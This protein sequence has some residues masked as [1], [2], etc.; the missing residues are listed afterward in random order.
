MTKMQLAQILAQEIRLI[1]ENEDLANAR[2]QLYAKRLGA[3]IS[4]RVSE[5]QLWKWTAKLISNGSIL[6]AIDIDGMPEIS[7]T[8]KDAAFLLELLADTSESTDKVFARILAALSYDIAGYQA[9]ALCLM[10]D[11]GDYSLDK[12]S[13]GEEFVETFEHP[14]NKIIP[15]IKLFLEKKIP[16]S[17]S[18]QN[19][20]KDLFLDKAISAIFK[21]NIHI[22]Q[23]SNS[24]YFINLAE[25]YADSFEQGDYLTNLSFSLLVTRARYFQ[26]RSLWSVISACGKDVAGVWGRYIR[27]KTNDLYDRNRI[28]PIEL[29]RSRFEF[30]ESQLSAVKAGILTTSNSYAIQMPTSAGKTMIGELIGLDSLTSSA[31]GKCL[32]IAPFRALANQVEADLRESLSP[33]GFSI[34]TISGSFE[35]DPFD[36]LIISETDVLVCTPEK[37]DILTRLRPEYFNNLSSVIIDEGHILG[38]V[39][40]GP[41]LELLIARLRQKYPQIRIAFISAVMP[42]ANGRQIANWLS[43]SDSGLIQAPKLENGKPWQPTQK[44]FGFFWWDGQVGEIVFPEVVVGRT[45]VNKPELAFARGL[46]DKKIVTYFTEKKRTKKTRIFPTDSNDKGETSALLGYEFAKRGP[47]LVF[48]PRPDWVIST[49]NKLLDLVNGLEAGGETVHSTFSLR[50]DL[51]SLIPALEW[52][53][54]HSTEYK[55]LRRGIGFHHGQLP[56]NLRRS[57]EDDYRDGNIQILFA[58][59]TVSQGINFPIKYLIVHSLVL[60]GGDDS[61]L[62]QRISKRDF[63][64]LVGRAGRAGRETEGQVIFVANRASDRATYTE[65]LNQDRVEP[66]ESIFLQVSKLLTTGRLTQEAFQK[67]VRDFSEPSLLGLLV[68][69]SISSSDRDLVESLIGHTLFKAQMFE[70]SNFA[71]ALTAIRDT[72]FEVPSRFKASVEDPVMRAAFTRTGLSLDSNLALQQFVQDNLEVISTNIS[73]LDILSIIHRNISFFLTSEIKEVTF[74][75]SD[76]FL[77]LPEQ[78]RLVVIESWIR[79]EPVGKILRSEIGNVDPHKFQKLLSQGLTYRYPWITSAILQIYAASC[80]VSLDTLPEEIRS[81]PTYLK[82]GVDNRNAALFLGV[83]VPSRSLAIKLSSHVGAGDVRSTIEW[84]RNISSEELISFGIN[85]YDTK[86][87]VDISYNLSRSRNGGNQWEFEVKGITYSDARK[88]V[89]R[90]LTIGSEVQLDR[91]PENIFDPFA[92]RVTKDG[93]EIGYVPRSVAR[94]IAPIIDLREGKLVAV[95]SDKVPVYDWAKIVIKVQL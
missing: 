31:T 35:L 20:T 11:I 40:R 75:G 84:L 57:I 68:E 82:Y 76:Y 28:K 51:R 16:L 27:L 34:S 2:A 85:E 36:D 72:F 77:N 19:E 32:Y 49:A 81:I 38:D 45:P 69:E 56:D 46:A 37:V 14:A 33:L 63:W 80:G 42:E 59:S 62:V 55:L 66:V 41:Q 86:L 8:F 48:T 22:L 18:L 73:A 23:G 65:F 10:K 6:A 26:K 71:P 61:E 17:A 39:E 89:A 29:R 58:N 3:R 50:S 43:G 87:I 52:Y 88:E 67:Y 4:I 95:V 94:T 9:N 60:R 91:E 12:I 70:N 78:D 90:L 74:D 44:V 25:A 47:T 1:R 30:W 21:W 24:D 5:E 79:G 13:T 54:E 93:N 64:N 83:G 15:L 7:G 92:I 53:G